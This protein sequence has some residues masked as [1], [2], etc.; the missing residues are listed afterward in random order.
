[1]N[2]IISYASFSTNEEYR[3]KSSSGGV[4]YEL[5]KS[6]ISRNGIVYGVSFGEEYRYCVYKRVT[7]INELE[8]ILGSKYLQPRLNDTFACVKSDLTKGITVLF[9]GTSCIINGLKSFLGKEYTNLYCVDVICHGVPSSLVW[10]KYIDSIEKKN[11]HKIVSFDFRCKNISWE[12]YGVKWIDSANRISFTELRNDPFMQL[13][14][15]NIS[16]RPSCFEC[17]A[18]INRKS[19]VSLG[20]FWG[21]DNVFPEMNDHKGISLVIVRTDQG[22]NLLDSVSSKLV[23]KPVCY[24]KAV[25]DNPAEYS[26]VLRPNER[27]AF[28]D[29]LNKKSFVYLFRKYLHISWMIRIKNRVKKMIGKMHQ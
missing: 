11:K 1:M 14:L 26:S 9:S 23:S 25:A 12:H 13:Y 28:F 3:L 15:R 29:E 5:S 16:L 22:A 24:A 10:E 6:I 7:S 27:N 19:D 2:D 20:D 21:I 4:F 18:K 8:S 17:R